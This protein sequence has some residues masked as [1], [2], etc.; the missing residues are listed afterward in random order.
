VAFPFVF[1][2]PCRL[3]RPGVA[4]PS[5]RPTERGDVLARDAVDDSAAV[6]SVAGGPST[7]LCRFGAKERA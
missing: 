5:S 2:K 6:S 7:V 1:H 4:D 3:G